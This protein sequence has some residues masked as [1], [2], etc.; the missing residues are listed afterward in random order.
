MSVGIKVS[1]RV[2]YILRDAYVTLQ[3]IEDEPLNATAKANLREIRSWAISITNYVN[4]IL[5]KAGESDDER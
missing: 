3:L 4:R 5:A 1:E 2:L